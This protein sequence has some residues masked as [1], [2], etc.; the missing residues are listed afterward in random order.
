MIQSFNKIEKVSG[1]LTLPGDKSISIRALIF[2]AL[3]DGE[4]EITNLPKSDDIKSTINCL[5][6]LG[7][8][9]KEEANRTKV[10]GRGIKGFAKLC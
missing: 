6:Q 9:I 2:S 10:Y 7:I 5:K 4:S 1:S 8:Q 3:A